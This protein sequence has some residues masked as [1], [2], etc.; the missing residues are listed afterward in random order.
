[1]R[2]AWRATPLIFVSDIHP[3]D[4]CGNAIASG[5][6][7]RFWQRIPPPRQT[8][9]A[10]HRRRSVRSRPPLSWFEAA[11]PVSRGRDQQRRQNVEKIVTRSRAKVSSPRR[12]RSERR[13][14]VHYVIGNHDRLL[15]RPR[16]AVDPARDDGR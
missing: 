6:F 10:G 8:P 14:Q 13:A 2:A 4:G 9:A 12:E 16:C 3:T 5:T 1:M 15:S 11:P 7:A